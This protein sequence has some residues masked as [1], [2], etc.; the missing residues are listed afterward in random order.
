MG[1]APVVRALE[2]GD[3]SRVA[4][5]LEADPSLVD[6]KGGHQQWTPLMAATLMGRLDMVRWLLDRG[7][8]IDL[9]GRDGETA[10]LLA[11]VCGRLE[12]VQL[13][14]ERGA[15][16]D[17]TARGSCTVLILAAAGGHVEIVRALLR[18]PGVQVSGRQGHVRS[19]DEAGAEGRARVTLVTHEQCAVMRGRAPALECGSGRAGAR[20]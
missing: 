19:E 17:V 9:P 2:A 18:H 7:A 20:W 11:A 3:M 6:A 16:T 15:S 10:L 12:V 5:L 8:S 14:L 13:L 1:D 4:Q